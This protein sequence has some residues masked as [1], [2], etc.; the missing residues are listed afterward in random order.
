MAG[1]KLLIAVSLSLLTLPAVCALAADVK[2]QSSIQHREFFSA[3]RGPYLL[4]CGY[5]ARLLDDSRND[6]IN[7]VE[8][9]GKSDFFR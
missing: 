4:N 3:G 6:P 7:A 8:Y 2:A 1:K 9:P 5:A